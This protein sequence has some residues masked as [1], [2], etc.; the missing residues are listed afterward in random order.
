MKIIIREATPDDAEAILALIRSVIA[1]GDTFMPI[2]PDEFNYTLEQQRDYLKRVA[3]SEHDAFLVAEE[4]GRLVGQLSLDGRR[5]KA[6]R[7]VAKLGISIHHGFR[8]KGIGTKL[9]AAAITWA[10]YTKHIHRI[11]L[12]VFANNLPAIRLYER[13]GF[14]QEGCRRNAV[15]YG[16]QWVDVMIMGLLI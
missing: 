13:F 3:A 11:E 5:H 2:Q 9:M 10:R 1:E 16:G 4:G 15:A 8:A 7:H 14:K 6:E 12:E